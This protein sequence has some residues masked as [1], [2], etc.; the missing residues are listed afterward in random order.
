M[1]TALLVA[2]ALSIVA[3]GGGGTAQ[4][5][6]AGAAPGPGRAW[7]DAACARASVTP[8]PIPTV[9]AMRALLVGRWV[10]CHPNPPILG[11]E[12]TQEGGYYVLDGQSDGQSK[13][14]HSEPGRYTIGEEL[15]T[16]S[17]IQSRYLQTLTPG[18]SATDGGAALFG[19]PPTLQFGF[20]HVRWP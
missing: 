10:T 13:R 7:L 18:G 3:C 11:R 17:G 8:R 1:K 14:R 5:A 15:N 9:E 4:P 19:P 6:E 16:N 12:F 2:S 20:T